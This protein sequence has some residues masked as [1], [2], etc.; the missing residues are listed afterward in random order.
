MKTTLASMAGGVLLIA[1][2]SGNGAG[3]T[4][5]TADTAR[6]HVER[7]DAGGGPIGL[8]GSVAFARITSG[9]GGVAVEEGFDAPDHGNGTYGYPRS[10]NVDLDPGSYTLHAYQRSCD[11]T[12]DSLDP[13][14]ERYSCQADLDLKAGSEATATIAIEESGCT[15]EVT[16]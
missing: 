16:P 14:A 8:E 13:P 6:L 10:L 2:G 1:C 4:S 3:E 11:G 12:C 5:S 9:D 7:E 15:V